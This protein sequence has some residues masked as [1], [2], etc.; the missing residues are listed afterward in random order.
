MLKLVNRALYGG[1]VTT[2]YNNPF[3]TD[4][5]VYGVLELLAQVNGSNITGLTNTVTG[6]IAANL[7]DIIQQ[8]FAQGAIGAIPGFNVNNFAPGQ[9]SRSLFDTAMD[10]N[11]Q[12]VFGNK[13]FGGSGPASIPK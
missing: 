1:I 12:T 11:D 3:S 5:M 6:G 9:G 13:G 2:K 10:R 7:L 4:Q 8:I